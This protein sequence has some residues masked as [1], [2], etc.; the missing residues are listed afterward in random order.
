MAST[1]A[2][3]LRDE[4]IGLP[5]AVVLY[6]PM[7]DL[8]CPGESFQTLK[9]TE[10]FYDYE[11]HIIPSFKAYADTADFKNPYVSSVYGDFNKGYSPTLIQGGTK[12]LLLSSF[13]RLYQSMDA[14]GV[15]VKLDIYE[16]MPHVFQRYSIPESEIALNKVNDFFK[17][18]LMN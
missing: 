1:T 3:R 14:A 8:S 11:K 9:A 17:E 12:E 5:A 4:G 7:G 13:V 18:H 15:D 2:L 10:G 16:G 6:S